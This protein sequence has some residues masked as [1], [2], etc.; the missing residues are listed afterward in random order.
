MGRVAGEIG[1]R[2]NRKYESI[3]LALKSVREVA[4]LDCVNAL[5]YFTP[6]RIDSPAKAR[7][8]PT[9]THLHGRFYCGHVLC[10]RDGS[11]RVVG[12]PSMGRT[13]W[14]RESGAD[15]V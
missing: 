9:C 6:Y 8:C 7:G 13:F 14:P 2:A 11:R 4:D 10:E 1:T 3:L 12:V 15:D 5:A